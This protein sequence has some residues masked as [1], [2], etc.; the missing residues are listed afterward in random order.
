MFVTFSPIQPMPLTLITPNL[1][2]QGVVQ[3][4]LRR[5]TDLL[6]DADSEHLVLT[7]ATFMEVGSRRVV[8]GAS[9][10]Q[11]PIADVLMAHPSGATES[12]GELR[13]SKQAVR[14]SVILSPF[15]VEGLIHLA[16]EPE[17]RL[18]VQ[19]LSEKWIPVTEARYWAYSVAESP[20]YVDLLVVNHARAH[21]AI[22]AGVEWRTTPPA[23]HFE[24]KSGGW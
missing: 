5:L 13:T 23:D 2:V 11:V 6:N 17:L 21:I 22:A 14:G 8:A 4:R 10:A 19:S 9:V 20:N 24:S 15:T 12:S 1:V 7:D 16:Y 18:A 3:T